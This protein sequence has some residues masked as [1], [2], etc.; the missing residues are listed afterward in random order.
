MDGQ[1]LGTPAYMSPEQARGEAHQVDGRTDVYSLGVMLYQMLT[2]ELPFRGTTRMLLHQVLHDEPRPPRRLNDRIP[3]DLET[4]CLKA[5]AKEPRRRYSTAAELAEDLRRYL[6][7]QPILARPVGRTE[8]LWRWCRRN[9]VL[10]G[11][12]AGIFLTLVLGMGVSIYFAVLAN[13]RAREAMSEKE[14]A[15]VQAAEA[16]SQAARAKASALQAREEKFLSNR[17]LYAADMA[18]AK[19]AWDDNQVADV[20]AF[21]DDMRPEHTGGIDL[22]GFEWHYLRR[23]CHSELLS[24]N[25]PA[26]PFYDAPTAMSSVYDPA[27]PLN[28]TLSIAFS[29]EGRAIACAGPDGIRVWDA[30]TGIET[31]RLKG[32]DGWANRVA[33]SQDGR[34]LAGAFL[35]RTVRVWDSRTGECSHVLSG[36]TTA[37][38]NLAFSPHGARLASSSSDR[39]VRI[40]DLTAGREVSCIKGHT[41]V[42]RALAFSPDGKRLASG[43][44]DRAVRIWDASTGKGFLSIASHTDGVLEVAF[45]PDGTRLAVACVD[46]PVVVFDA[47]TGDE[48]LSLKGHTELVTGIEFNY[49]GTRLAS[50][51][52]DGVR[53]WNA[54]TGEEELLLKGPAS[55]A[56]SV[57]FSPDGLRLAS[58]GWDGVV[59]LSDAKAGQ[60][61]VLLRGYY[62][63]DSATRARKRP[64]TPTP[65]EL[66]WP[67]LVDGVAF[68]PDGTR[69]A[70]ASLDKTVR[71]WDV[72]AGEQL[73]AFKG[74]SGFVTSVAFSPNGQ[75]LA[76]GS[77][78][79]TVRVWDV[80]TGQ[81]KTLR[82]HG[83]RVSSVAYSPDSM[84]LASSSDDGTVRIWNA[85]TGQQL[86]CL[87]EYSGL[88]K[89]WFKS[90]VNSVAFSSDGQRLAVAADDSLRVLDARTGQQVLALKGHSGAIHAVAYSRDGSRLAS[91][92]SD[93]TVR[94]WDGQTGR[95]VSTLK[96]HTQFVRIVAFSPDG[97]RVA[98]AANDG[99]RLWDAATG[100]EVFNLMPGTVLGAAFSPDGSRLATVLRDHTIKIWEAHKPTREQLLQRE[101]VGLVQS[102]F[103]RLVLKAQVVEVLRRDDGLPE[104]LRREALARVEHYVL[105]P[106]ELN[107]ESWGIA[108]KPAR[109]TAFYQKA[110]LKMEEAC[111]LVPE[112]GDYLN[113]LGM[114]LYRTGQYGRAVE[115]LT[116][117]EKL[118]AQAKGLLPDD[119][120]FLAMA[121]QQLGHKEEAQTALTRLR[122]TMRSGWWAA[123]L[124]AK[125]FTIEAETL[126]QGQMTKPGK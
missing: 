38:F 92:S 15:D 24:V 126:I 81:V 2:R 29:P 94:I 62:R 93:R 97:A 106:E 18:L 25:G 63:A 3:R 66:V 88:F 111:R 61:G 59:R 13:D 96:G 105:D 77:D 10:A 28:P 57:A 45:S 118:N 115:I 53:V 73:Q 19:R 78:D 107:R 121:H 35:D 8:R 117:S 55:R 87:S 123:D 67:S 124:E 65:P 72:I 85:V 74:H 50:A 75:R 16:A 122:Q 4:I 30:W 110:V 22:R 108:S 5:M 20:E 71:I 70:T 52:W 83:G 112:Q 44:I 23:L 113:T 68:S 9:P 119:L 60:Q 7:H 54:R 34:R 103:D 36:H 80:G 102:L 26:R 91:A 41:G 21:L 56:S 64:W 46:R 49:D 31:V 95:L 17:R 27:R 116:R 69:L 114:A 98:S 32:S 43:P 58:P 120:A 6:A 84:H 12:T 125:A 104:E 42:V 100:Q 33:F 101:A 47:Q 89:N 109:D 76:S 51:A 82:G 40:W 48:L 86:L 11:L 39:T 1:V 37:V 90:P 99:V 14:R 79:S